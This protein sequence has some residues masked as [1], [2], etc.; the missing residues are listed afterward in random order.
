MELFKS[1][2]ICQNETLLISSMLGSNQFLIIK[3]PIKFVKSVIYSSTLAF[4]WAF[5]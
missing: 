4:S 2:H 1:D 5:M 3:E